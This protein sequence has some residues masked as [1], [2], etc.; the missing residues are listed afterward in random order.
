MSP[1]V[2]NVPGIG[3][4]GPLHWQSLWEQSDP[5]ILRVSQRDWNHPS[6]AEWVPALEDALRQ[7]S[8]PVIVVAHSLGCLALAHCSATAHLLIKAALLVAIPDPEGPTFPSEAT[9]FAPVPKQPFAFPSVVVAST[10]DPFGSLEHSTMYAQAWGS[11]LVSIGAAGH[12]N[13]DSGL[14]AWPDGFALLRCL[15]N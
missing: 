6:C 5:D 13:A 8:G 12:I 10:D 1:T 15:H 2:L 11:R 3:N 14:G 4:S 7:V 9:G